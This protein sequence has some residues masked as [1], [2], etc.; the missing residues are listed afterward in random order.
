VSDH[1]GTSLAR[2]FLKSEVQF[3]VVFIKLDHHNV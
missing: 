3:V 1:F 2:L